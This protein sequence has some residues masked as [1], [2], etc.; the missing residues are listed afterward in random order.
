MAALDNDATVVDADEPVSD[1]DLASLV[2][3][4]SAFNAAAISPD[5]AEAILTVAKATA[6]GLKTVAKAI[7]EQGGMDAV[8][9]RIAEQYVDAFKEVAQKTNTVLLP[10]DMGNPGSMIAQALTVFES[11]KDKKDKK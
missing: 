6:E 7:G 4:S 5:E 10:T 3:G 9:L 11:I 2:D 1:A 8:S